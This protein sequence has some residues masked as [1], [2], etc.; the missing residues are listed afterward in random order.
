MSGYDARDAAKD[1]NVTPGEVKKAWHDSRT[2]SGVRKG[3]DG[4][5]P[6]PQNRADAK[7]LTRKVMDRARERPQDRER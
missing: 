4:D 3:G 6:T 1:T 5:R 2:V 7:E